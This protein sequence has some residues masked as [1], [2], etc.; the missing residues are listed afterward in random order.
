[1]KKFLLVTVAT[2]PLL[3]VGMNPASSQDIKERGKA[4]VS[5]SQ[6]QAHTKEV[7]GKAQGAAKM[8]ESSGAKLNQSSGAQGKTEQARSEKGRIEQGRTEGRAVSGREGNAVA[9]GQG[10]VGG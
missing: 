5:Q 10:K 1:M 2:L 6:G 4:G 3:A 7:Q 8:N 9:A